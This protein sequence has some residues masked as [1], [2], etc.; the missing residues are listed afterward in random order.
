MDGFLSCPTLN[1]VKTEVET[2]VCRKSLDTD[3]VDMNNRSRGRE[4][5]SGLRKIKSQGPSHERGSFLLGREKGFRGEVP[6]GL[7]LYKLPWG[8]SGKG[9]PGSKEGMSKEIGWEGLR[10][11]HLAPSP[12]PELLQ[13]KG[14]SCLSVRPPAPVLAWPRADR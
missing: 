5:L 6:F 11:P 1:A 12:D 14:E 4:Q 10:A 3:A 13:M 7:H 9:P 8:I 2:Q